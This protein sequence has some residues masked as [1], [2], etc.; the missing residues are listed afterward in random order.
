MQLPGKRTTASGADLVW[1]IHERLL[2]FK[3]FP[4][5]GEVALAV[6]PTSQRREWT[7]VLGGRGNRGKILRSPIWKK[8]IKRIEAKLKFVYC[9]RG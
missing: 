5:T 8:R 6:V 9:L 4:R 7:V 1:M 2:S 3:D